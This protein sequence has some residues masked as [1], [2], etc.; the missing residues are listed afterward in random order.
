MVD[1]NWKK[2]RKW[3]DER[4]NGAF[5]LEQALGRIE[6]KKL[7]ARAFS[8][9]GDVHHGTLQ[10][11]DE[12][13]ETT[14]DFGEL[15][16]NFEDLRPDPNNQLSFT[17]RLEA[18]RLRIHEVEIQNLNGT[19]TA[20]GGVYN[21]QPL[22]F[23]IFEGEV[24]GRLSAD[25]REAQPTFRAELS[26]GKISL[27]RLY[28]DLAGQELLEGAVSVEADLSAPGLQ[29]I[30][31]GLNGSVKISG[32]N[33]ILHGFDLD[34]FIADFRKNRKVDL[35]DIGSYLFAGPIGVLIKE[36]YDLSGLYRNL[37][38]EKRET[39]EKFEFNWLFENGRA[40]TQD[41]AFRT[42]ENRVAFRGFL[43]L[44]QRRYGEFTLGVLDR[45][46]CAEITEEITGPL[47]KPTVKK[48]GLM[49]FHAGPLAD[50]LGKV[51]EI[52]DPEECQLFYS[53][54]VAHPQK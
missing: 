46:G 26:A 15:D 28:R 24:K 21:I 44:P 18:G 25:R 34:G 39:L 10:F 52:F 20:N 42:N 16:L 22:E 38:R 33:I 50:V 35:V 30:I 4:K 31:N 51:L 47:S 37:D 32:T 8:V 36:G 40:R 9:S 23:S 5:N 1:R 48:T 29:G 41:V 27:A 17:G 12:V 7:A 54:Q 49:R 45:R 2:F 19:L 53:G 43:D 3:L 13:S 11:T 6:K 14:L